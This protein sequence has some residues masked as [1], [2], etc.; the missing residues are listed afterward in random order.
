[1]Y[2]VATAQELTRE[3]GAILAPSLNWKDQVTAVHRALSS[4]HRHWKYRDLR[5]S[6]VKTWFYGEA[7]RVDYHYVEALKELR[8][9][10][11]LKRAKRRIAADANILAA[12]HSQAG[13]PLDSDVIVA[14]GALARLVDLPRAGGDAR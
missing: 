12:H 7:R 11:E 5:W 6:K 14:L 10:E 3:C 2:S 13:T 4:E 1:M 8:A 9:E